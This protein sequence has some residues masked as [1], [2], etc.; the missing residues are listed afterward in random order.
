MI[1]LKFADDFVVDAIEAARRREKE[2]RDRTAKER[3]A[4]HAFASAPYRP[5]SDKP[6]QT[7]VEPL[8]NRAKPLERP[9]GATDAPKHAE[10][11]WELSRMEALIYELCAQRDWATAQE[12]ERAIYGHNVVSSTSAHLSAVR[13][14]VAR[15][16]IVIDIFRRGSG[17]RQAYCREGCA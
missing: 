7:F 13:R 2:A 1:E 14:K 10:A 15:F 12:L 11:S 17:M 16:G 6:S 5:H 8:F 9:P 4:K 3:A